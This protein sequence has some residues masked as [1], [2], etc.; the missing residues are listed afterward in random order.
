MLPDDAELIA[1]RL[2]DAAWVTIPGELQSLLGKSI[3]R[4]GGA[5]VPRVFVAGLSNDY[6]GYFL[7]P[8][9][10]RRI[11]YVSCASLYGPDAGQLLAQTA[12]TLI[13]QLANDGMRR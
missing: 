4:A 6:L 9:D 3:K 13:R 1:V 8:E 2:G 10:Y 12:E 5:A 11:R 7:T